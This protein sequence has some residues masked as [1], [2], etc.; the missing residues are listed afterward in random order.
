LHQVAL[1]L[2]FYHHYFGC[3][4]PAYVA[5]STGR[6]MH[7]WRVLV[8]PYLDEQPLYA[9]YNFSE[10]WDGPNNSKLAGMMPNLYACPGNGGASKGLTSY[11]VIA[12]P[13]T[14]FPGGGTTSLADIRDDKSRTILVAESVNARIPWLQPLDLDV[15]TMSLRINDPKRPSLST[16]HPGG[17]PSIGFADGWVREFD[18]SLPPKTLKALIT[19]NGG[20]VIEH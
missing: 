3:F 15:R 9:A 13:G 5:D 11:V 12:G 20:E 14:S 8:L 6:P 2:Q 7:S 10:P 17:S 16:L 18:E 19:I 4:P 1:A